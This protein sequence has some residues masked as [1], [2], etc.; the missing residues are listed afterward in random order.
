MTR[1]PSN[2]STF[3]RI[4]TRLRLALVLVAVTTGVLWLVSVHQARKIMKTY[5]QLSEIALPM[6]RQA[7]QMQ[8][9]LTSLTTVVGQINTLPLDQDTKEGGNTIAAISASLRSSLQNLHEFEDV[10]PEIIQLDSNLDRVEAASLEMLTD[11]TLLQEL[12]QSMHQH[13][14]DIT[15]I[16]RHTQQILENLTL[17][18]SSRTT[19]LI[20]GLNDQPS[21]RQE[22]VEE[23]FATLV[24]PSLTISKL[25]FELDRVVALVQASSTGSTSTP[26]DR[27]AVLAQSSLKRIVSQ[28]S[29]LAQGPERRELS[30]HVAQL[31]SILHGDKGIFAQL[32]TQK[33]VQKSYE[34]HRITQQVQ[35]A[36][37]TRLTSN[38]VARSH[39]IVQQASSGLR[40]AI[41]NILWTLV[42]AVSIGMVVIFFTNYSIIERQFSR[43]ILKLNHSV[44]A[45]ARGDLDHPVP[46]IGPDELGDMANALVVFKENAEAL[47]D[48]N[49]ELEKFAYIAA[50]DLRSPLRAIRELCSWTLE[51]DENQL[52]PESHAY[53]TL[54]EERAI[55]LNR[56]LS[57]LLSYVQ[58]GHISAEAREVDLEK[59]IRE[60]LELQ[61]INK[62]FTLEYTGLSQPIFAP[63]EALKTICSNLLSNVVKHHDREFGKIAVFTTLSDTSLCLEITDDGGGI[64][65]RYHEQVFDLFQTLKSRDEVEGSGL[66]LAIIKKLVKSQRGTISLASTPDICRGT[67]ITVNLPL[68]SRTARQD[69]PSHAQAA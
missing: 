60:Q 6:L 1:F 41:L 69:Q 23:V 5:D 51:D 66:G 14:Q 36:D 13:R 47:R 38:L 46:S 54:L 20:N 42:I 27:S 30:T 21:T 64:A 68:G 52:T 35:T 59:L 22:Q 34:L 43:R 11:R 57:D 55:R 45:I 65:P 17:D 4:T 37:T 56:H 29:A 40:G 61:D 63:S 49:D 24:L 18:I 31:R 50:H 32:E 2:Y 26:P 25:S 3:K 58:V 16:H 44:L 8:Q 33:E 7:E 10:H 15:R 48:S 39:A 9:G 28:L 53:L 19:A 62:R 12:D 67:T